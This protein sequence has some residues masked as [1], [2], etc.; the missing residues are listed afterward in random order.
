MSVWQIP[1]ASILTCTCRGPGAGIARSWISIGAPRV[2]TTAARI[3]APSR[4]GGAADLA[5]AGF[6]AV[7]TVPWAAARPGGTDDLDPRDLSQGEAIARRNPKRRTRHQAQATAP[8]G[9]G[10]QNDASR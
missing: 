4:P 9:I 7:P 5:A 8:S 2:G 10:A 1:D 3:V 6:L